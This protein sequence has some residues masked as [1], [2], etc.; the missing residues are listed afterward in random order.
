MLCIFSVSLPWTGEKQEIRITNL[1]NRLFPR[2]WPGWGD[3]RTHST[4]TAKKRRKKQKKA[5]NSWFM[6]FGGC[7]I[8][9]FFWVMILNHKNSAFWH[10][11]TPKP[12]LLPVFL[13]FIWPAEMH[14]FRTRMLPNDK[15]HFFFYF[16]TSF[17]NLKSKNNHMHAKCK[18]N[19]Q[20]PKS[21][22]KKKCLCPHIPVLDPF[23]AE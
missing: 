3:T 21:K 13:I 18:K 12:I 9:N 16:L 20:N 4:R 22:H 23:N 10:S 2:P 5:E 1:I 17:C 19:L 8:N 7:R 6:C 14:P 11:F 15:D